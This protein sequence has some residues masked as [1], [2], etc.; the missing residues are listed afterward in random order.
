VD[1][2]DPDYCVHPSGKVRKTGANNLMDRGSKMV[3]ASAVYMKSRTP[4]PAMAMP[5]PSPG[6]SA[7]DINH[8]LGGVTG[9]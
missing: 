8:N 1:K 2:A 6:V 5:L 7:V 9:G 4:R 3:E